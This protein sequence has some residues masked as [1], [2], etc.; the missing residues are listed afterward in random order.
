MRLEAAFE[1]LSAAGIEFAEFQCKDCCPNEHELDLALRLD[2]TGSSCPTIVN[3]N[4]WE[5]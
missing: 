2:L 4:H 5:N 1:A 3:L